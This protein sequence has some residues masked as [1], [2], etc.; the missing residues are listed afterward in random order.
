MLSVHWSVDESQQVGHLE[1]REDGNTKVV[2]KFCSCPVSPSLM[3]K[4]QSQNEE[5]DQR[6]ITMSWMSE[7]Q[8]TQYLWLAVMGYSHP[9]RPCYDSASPPINE[10]PVVNIR[11]DECQEFCQKLSKE[12]GKNVSLPTETQL[13]YACQEKIIDIHANVL[14]WCQN[15][16]CGIPDSC[17]TN[18]NECDITCG[19]DANLSAYRR[20]SSPGHQSDRLGFRIVISNE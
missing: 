17:V 14:D 4:Q 3:E 1:I 2:Y 13:K 8:V 11:R 10:R 7:K 16:Y 6:N 15:R 5:N 19:Y 12:I 18:S 20:V 9:S